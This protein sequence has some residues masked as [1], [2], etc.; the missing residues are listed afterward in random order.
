MTRELELHTFAR[1]YCIDRIAHWQEKYIPVNNAAIGRLGSQG[2]TYSDKAYDIFPRY[3]VLD[4]I[5][6]EVE[7]LDP[8]ELPDMA[9]LATLLISV[10][11]RASSAVTGKYDNRIG[12]SAEQDERDRFADAIEKVSSGE[13]ASQEPLF[14]R[15]VLN[16]AE[17]AELWQK[18]SDKWGVTG[19]YWYP[20]GNRTH[21]SLVALRL[22]DGDEAKLQR[23]LGKFLTYQGAER[24]YELREHGR[25]NYLLDPDAAEPF[26]NGAEGY[27][28][29]D[30][31]DW[32]VYCS[33]EQT[34]TL[35][36]TIANIARKNFAAMVI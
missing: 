28:F 30:T 29:S 27:W 32:I 35:G 22:G 36:G 31:N 20:S 33:H 5:L 7:S 19:G 11:Y 12:L 17:V 3:N 4:A 9:E 24:I 23:A 15:R 8:E 16:T 1:R 18:I 13:L 25:E 14:Y 21:A 10:G 6:L 26:Y 2:Y 34:M